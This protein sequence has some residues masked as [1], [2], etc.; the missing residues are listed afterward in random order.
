MTKKRSRS[1][2]IRHADGLHIPRSL[3]PLIASR[4]LTRTLT[5][6]FSQQDFTT[7]KLCPASWLDD[8]VAYTTAEPSAA[9][10]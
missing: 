7:R 4:E 8:G 5:E 3:R 9:F 2:Y 6:I 1:A 10:L